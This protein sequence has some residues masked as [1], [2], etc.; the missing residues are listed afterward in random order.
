M[1]PGLRDRRGV[2]RPAYLNLR[3]VM[4]LAVMTA[5]AVVLALLGTPR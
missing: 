5:A 4:A 1:I 3:G 2:R